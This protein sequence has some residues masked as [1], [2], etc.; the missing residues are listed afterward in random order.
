M[1]L[2]SHWA[3]LLVF[4]GLVLVIA[5]FGLSV[6][7]QFPA[8]HRKPELKGTLGPVIIAGCSLVVVI[9]AVRA[10]WLAAV[11]LPVPA[12]IIGAGAAALAAPLVLQQL[13]DGV[14]DGRAGL[15]AMAAFIGAM[16]FLNDFVHG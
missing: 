9:A 11:G 3:G 1:S 8:E 13:P 7:G 5:V 15:I 10:V 2:A 12:A 6:S 16:A 4:V 14:V